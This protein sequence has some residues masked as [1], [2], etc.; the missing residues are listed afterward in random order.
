MALRIRLGSIG[1]PR[2]RVGVRAPGRRLVAAVILDGGDGFSQIASCADDGPLI[3]LVSP[4]RWPMRRAMDLAVV[5]KWGRVRGR[6]LE[7][8]G[9]NE[10][11]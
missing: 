5:P 3:A 2:G 8:E 10:V 7:K 9:E 4:R 6:A 1:R 11:E